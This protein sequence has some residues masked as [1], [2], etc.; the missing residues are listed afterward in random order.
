MVLLVAFTYVLP[1]IPL[2]RYPTI[3]Q[4]E[5]DRAAFVEQFI[6]NP[7]MSDVTLVCRDL[8]M[9]AERRHKDSPGAPDAR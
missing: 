7:R 2:G 1:P 8:D 9:P 3:E 4:C 6:R 5:L